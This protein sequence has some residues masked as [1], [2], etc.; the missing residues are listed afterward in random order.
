V[1]QDN[2]LVFF[3]K[4]WTAASKTGFAVLVGLPPINKKRSA[5]SGEV[6]N[7]AL[8]YSL[9]YIIAHE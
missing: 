4:L 1:Q 2:Y 8:H 9:F 7:F 5:I 6:A 3:G